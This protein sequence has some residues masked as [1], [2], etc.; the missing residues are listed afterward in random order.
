M[1]RAGERPVADPHGGLAKLNEHLPRVL[2]GRTLEELG[3]RRPS[4]L[5][6]I[7]PVFGGTATNDPYTL[8]LG[9]EYYAEWPPSAL[10]VNPETLTFDPQR[11]LPWLPVVAGD[12]GFA[13]HAS[14]NNTHYIGQLVCCSFTAEF[15]L[16]LHGVQTEHVWDSKRHTFGATIHRVERALRSEYYKGRHAPLPAG[17]K[18]AA[19]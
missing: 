7:I 8:R 12:P 17:A 15:Y 6:L 16:S 5:T 3:W 19:P 10:F 9:F 11:D 1:A 2:A 4:P 18:V 14:Y 13:L